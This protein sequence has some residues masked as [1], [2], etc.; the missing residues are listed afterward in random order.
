MGETLLDD[1]DRSIVN[2]L[3]DGF[4]V[5]ARPYRTV[6]RRLH[7]K[8]S[9]LILRLK[10]LLHMGVLTRF[11]PLFQIERAGGQYVLCAMEVDPVRVGEVAAV[12]ASIPEV[13]HNYERT[14]A[15]NVWFVV[16]AESADDA[17]A[18]IERIES[19]TGLS[20]L[21]FPKLREFYVDLRF[22]A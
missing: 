12:L 5:A 4:P 10:R 1:V 3:Q 16:A 18:A 6:A 8:E 7:L 21:R 22:K 15:L 19:E 14:H 13:A 9:D 11:G 17:R 2:E 20:V